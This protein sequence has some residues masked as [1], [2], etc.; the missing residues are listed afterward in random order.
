MTNQPNASNRPT[1]NFGREYQPKTPFRRS[2]GSLLATLAV[3][4]TA[5]T[6]TNCAGVTSAASTGSNGS[7]DPGTGILSASATTLSFGSVAMGSTA[8]QSMS[9]TNTGTEA[10]NIAQASIPDPPLP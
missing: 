10:M 2:L 1:R 8:V 6:L 9:V 4:L 5:I 7:A 3:I